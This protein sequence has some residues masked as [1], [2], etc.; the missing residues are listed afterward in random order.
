MELLGNFWDSTENSDARHS[1]RRELGLRRRIPLI[2]EDS[3]GGRYDE[4]KLA[5]FDLNAIAHSGAN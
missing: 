4:A 2:R 1:D 3:L 5:K